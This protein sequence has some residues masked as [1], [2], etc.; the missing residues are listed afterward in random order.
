MKILAYFV[1]LKMYLFSWLCNPSISLPVFPHQFRHLL[2]HLPARHSL[3]ILT[4]CCMS[5]HT[6][7]EVNSI[8]K[9]FISYLALCSSFCVTHYVMPSIFYSSIIL[10]EHFGFQQLTLVLHKD[11]HLFVRAKRTLGYPYIYIIL[12]I[13]KPLD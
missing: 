1:S 12:S 8:L 4:H 2:N 7:T 5:C 11:R 13:R 6:K 3:P 9:L 10:T